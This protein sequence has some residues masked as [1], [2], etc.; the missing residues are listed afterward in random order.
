MPSCI[1]SP[2]APGT[3]SSPPGSQISSLHLF[4]LPW[5][6][7]VYSSV[8]LPLLWLVTASLEFGHKE[9]LLRFETLE[10]FDQSDDLD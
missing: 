10:T 6:L 4:Q 1:K 7:Y 3:K 5:Q 8:Y 2:K 9:L